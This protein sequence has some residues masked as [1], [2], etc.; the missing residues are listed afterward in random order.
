MRKAKSGSS[1][2]GIKT[3]SPVM[4]AAGHRPIYLM[5][6]APLV[7]DRPARP[8]VRLRCGTATTHRSTHQAQAGHGKHQGC[9]LGHR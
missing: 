7:P 4:A 3:G 5:P 1:L 6:E 2:F 9:R 8:T